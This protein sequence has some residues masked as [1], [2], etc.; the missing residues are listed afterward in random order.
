MKPVK[1]EIVEEGTEQEL[2]ANGAK[3]VRT[4]VVDVEP[5]EEDFGRCH[6][7]PVRDCIGP[8][9][10]MWHSEEE[11]AETEGEEPLDGCAEV[12]AAEAQID[13]AQAQ[14]EFFEQQIEML[15]EQREMARKLIT[16]E[17]GRPGEPDGEK[18]GED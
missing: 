3:K 1:T 8:D 16:G 17:A 10:S 12:L 4:E 2:R 11:D 5:E 13:A 14:M 6:R 9:C 7:N 18:A 15:E